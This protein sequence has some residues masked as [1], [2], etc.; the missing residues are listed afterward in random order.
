ME[1]KQ[2]NLE[3]EQETDVPQELNAKANPSLGRKWDVSV[4]IALIAVLIS[5]ASTWISL[6]EAK[7]MREQQSVLSNQQEASVWPYLDNTPYN[8]YQGDTIAEFTYRVMNKGVGPAIIDSVIYRFDRTELAPWGLGGYLRN[9][10]PNLT[11]EQPQNLV[12]DQTVLAPGEAHKVISIILKK[13]KGDTTNL[14]R[15]NNEIT[16]RYVLEY[17]YCSVYGKCW[18]VENWRS[19]SRSEDCSFRKGI[20]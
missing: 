17:C 14:I 7:I 11:I 5:L 12:L 8:N 2:P 3:S 13:S 6:Q 1:E 4:I 16:N 19:V 15:I 9:R 10:Y 18:K 20:R